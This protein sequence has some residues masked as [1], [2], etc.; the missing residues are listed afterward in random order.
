[1]HTLSKSFKNITVVHAEID[2]RLVHIGSFIS[3][4]IT[5]QHDYIAISTLTGRIDTHRSAKVATDWLKA[6][7][8]VA[9]RQR[10]KP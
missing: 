1:M 3:V 5:P 6:E 10:W 9:M 4:P 8:A 7:I 2:N